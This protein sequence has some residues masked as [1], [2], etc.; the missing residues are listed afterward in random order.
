MG[1]SEGEWL[2]V[3]GLFSAAAI[4]GEWLTALSA[5]ASA[6]GTD[7]G[8]LIGIGADRAVPFNWISGVG[9]EPLAE[10]RS[11][12]GGDPMVNP[13]VRVGLASPLLKSWH[14]IDCFDPEQQAQ[15][16]DYCEFCIRHDLPYG[17]QAT[18]LRDREILIGMSALRRARD[19]PPSPADRR[20]FELLAPHVRDAVR[21]QM[22]L[23]GRGA[24]LMAGALEAVGAA[25]FVFDASGEVRALTPAAEAAVGQ[26]PLRLSGRRLTTDRED[27]ARTLDLLLGQAIHQRDPRRHPARTLVLHAAHDPLSPIFLDISALPPKPFALGFEPRALVVL[28][29]HAAR[30]VALANDLQRAF[31]LTPSEAEIAIRLADGDGRDEIAADR[32]ASIE[33]VRS[34]T[35]SLYSKLGVRRAAELSA[36]LSR[37]R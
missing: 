26:G 37:L 33:T 24:A 6:C 16:P 17:S 34:Q 28:R 7:R 23:E 32:G 18:L 31:G 27:D 22:T 12:G 19:G 11:I 36:K 25:A 2:R 21:L 5:F 8:Q 3:A 10:F 1:I 35:K 9:P 30:D 14:D 29:G 15:S 20:A 13:R 4:D